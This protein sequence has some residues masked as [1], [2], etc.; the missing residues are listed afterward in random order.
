MH[1]LETLPFTNSFATLPAAFYARVQP[2]PLE[3]PAQLIHLNTAAA[4]LLDLNPDIADDPGFADLFS[5][6]HIPAGADPI[7]MPYA[8]HQFGHYVAQL[9]DGRA[10]MLGE[11]TN[12]HGEKWEIQLKGS[13]QTPWSRGGDGRA[14]LRSPIRE[15]L[16]SE[17]MHGL[18]IPTTR[19]L[20][21]TGSADEVYREQI[22]TA[23]IIT[24]LAPSHVRF[25]SF[26]LFF[27]RNQHDELRQLADYVIQQH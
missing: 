25:G 2:T 16:C 5:G 22:E 18:G 8:G 17:A 11:T 10:I 1:T 15:Y 27:Y 20:C 12:Q 24:R 23:A 26:E 21:I 3:K 14:V 7:A 13:G 19:A 9:G 4:E 6:K